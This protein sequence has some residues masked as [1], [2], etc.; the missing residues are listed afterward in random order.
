MVTLPLKP[1]RGG[2]LRPFGCGWFIREFLLGHGPNG[3]PRIDPAVGAPQADIFHHYKMAL[4][5]ATAFDKATRAE[6]KRAKREK[7]LIDPENIQR[8]AERYLARMPYKAQGCRFHS[9]V[10]Y[11]SNLQRLGWVEETGKEEPSAFQDH[12]PPGPPR[13]YFCLTEK[14]KSTPDYLWADPRKTLYS[15]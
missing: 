8:L 5:R 13:R 9:F 6:E 11:F 10:V 14:G 1:N 12:Y 3:S 4:I 15:H 7:R 2:F